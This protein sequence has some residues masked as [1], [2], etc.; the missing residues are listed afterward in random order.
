VLKC[1]WQGKA[2][3]HDELTVKVTFTDELTGREFTEQKVVRVKLPPA[4]QGATT[5]GAGAS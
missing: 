3:G 2:P 5:K 1:P 4:T